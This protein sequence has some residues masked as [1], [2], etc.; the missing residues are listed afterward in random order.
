[1]TTKVG[2]LAEGTGNQHGVAAAESEGIAK[3][4]HLRLP[5]LYIHGTADEIVPFK[6]GKALCDATPFARGFVAV[7]AGRHEDNA[8]AGGA[9]LR[10]A[11][12]R[13]VEGAVQSR[14]RATS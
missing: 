2:L 12:S 8:A 9:A 6:M 4:A 1:L 11:I 7:P 3:V 14:T 5:V 13:F 10:F